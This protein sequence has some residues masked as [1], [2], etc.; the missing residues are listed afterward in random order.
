MALGKKKETETKTENKM[1]RVLLEWAGIEDVMKSAVATDQTVR[2]TL[3]KLPGAVTA[4]VNEEK[5][6]I[7]FD[8]FGLTFFTQIK[9][10]KDGGYFVSFPSFKNSKGEWNDVVTMYDKNFHALIKELL[11]KLTN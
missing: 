3:S 9:A 1:E 6:W 10:K 8:F 5:M 4:T 7:K 2:Y 11:E